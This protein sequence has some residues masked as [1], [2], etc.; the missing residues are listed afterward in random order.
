MWLRLFTYAPM[1]VS[2]IESV[3]RLID[4]YRSKMQ[5]KAAGQNTEVEDKGIKKHRMKLV[6]L[7]WKFLPPEEQERATKDEFN[8]FTEATQN[9][10]QAAID[11]VKAFIPLRSV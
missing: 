1:I 6:E 2:G 8:N 7:L 5:A 4:L 3:I 10:V 9:L 11:W